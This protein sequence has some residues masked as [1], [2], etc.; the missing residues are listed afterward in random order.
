[1]KKQCV[2]L[3]A[4]QALREVT[5][6]ACKDWDKRNRR[7]PKARAESAV[8][9]YVTLIPQYP[10]DPEDY[11]RCIAKWM[12]CWQQATDMNTRRDLIAML[13]EYLAAMPE[14]ADYLTA[15]IL[16]LQK[17]QAENVGVLS[18]LIAA[19]EGCM[20]GIPV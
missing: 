11:T 7:K 17:E 18:A 1:M 13:Q 12:A 10:T 15:E 14:Y 6:P 19:Y 3:T 4:D 20:T 9:D 5:Q 2:T 16:R 8:V